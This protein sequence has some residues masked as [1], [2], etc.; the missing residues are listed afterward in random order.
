MGSTGMRVESVPTL[1]SLLLFGRDERVA[2]LLPRAAL[3]ATRFGGDNSQ[4]PVVERVELR[5]NL[6]T[7]YES[8]LRFTARYVDLL[9]TRPARIGSNPFE[10]TPVPAR[11]NYHRRAVTEAIANT[12]IHRDLALRDI[13]TRLHIFDRAI[14]I[15]N[16]RRSAGF[17]PAAL[18]AIRYGVPQRLNPQI[19]AMFTKPAYG[20]SLPTGGLPMRLRLA[21]PVSN[22]LPGLVAFNDEFR[23]RLHGI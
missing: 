3:I 1:A 7:I 11:A 23:I 20:L 6:A 15:A 8:A 5:G 2:E 13:T 12:V 4:A 9:E 17:A 16:P 10:E 14:E 22:R 18:K 19:A 21:G